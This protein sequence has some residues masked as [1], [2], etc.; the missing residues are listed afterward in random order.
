MEL[1]KKIRKKYV[2]KPIRRPL[3]DPSFG[4]LFIVVIGGIGSDVV[5]N[6]KDKQRL[7]AGNRDV[8]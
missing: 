3:K 1:V 5:Q 4:H 8:Y 7:S 2:M 6:Q